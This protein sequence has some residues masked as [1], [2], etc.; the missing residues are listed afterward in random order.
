MNNLDFNAGY[1]CGALCSDGCI[2]FSKKFGNYCISLET[3]DLDFALLFKS[4]LYE[5]TGKEPSLNKRK[6]KY[7]DYEHFTHVVT[8]WG[9]D[10]IKNFIKKY[11]LVTGP[12]SWHVPKIAYDDEIFRKGFLQGFFDGSGHIRLR[13][14]KH[15]DEHFQKCRT[16]RITSVNETGI[17]EIKK[18][19]ELEGVNSVIYSNGSSFILEIDGLNRVSAFVKKINFGIKRKKELAEAFLDPVK[20]DKIIKENH[21]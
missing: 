17:N 9:K 18:L 12:L 10:I 16:L 15:K 4:R 1:V 7:K 14:R 5:V 20:F 3:K 2:V 8:L 21:T 13:L 6:R 19:L 11:N